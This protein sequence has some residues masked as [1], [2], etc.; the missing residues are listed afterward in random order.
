MS[1]FTDYTSVLMSLLKKD[2]CLCVALSSEWRLCV[3][4]SSSEWRL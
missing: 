1:T 3:A 2:I 4:L